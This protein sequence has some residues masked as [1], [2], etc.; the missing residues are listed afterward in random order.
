MIQA[1]E[2]L[3]YAKQCVGK[4]EVANRVAV[5]RAYYA[6]YHICWEIAILH[7]YNEYLKNTK[8][9]CGEHEKLIKFYRHKNRQYIEDKLRDLKYQRVNADYKLEEIDCDT[10]TAKTTIKKV[11]RLIKLVEPF[12]TKPL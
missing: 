3:E 11:E 1:S 10:N 2:F 8:L 9:N 7:G 5:S 12:R 4:S 6:V